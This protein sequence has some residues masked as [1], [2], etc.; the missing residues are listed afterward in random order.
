[1]SI[2]AS[3]GLLT[4]DYMKVTK[5]RVYVTPKSFLDLLRLYRYL[6]KTKKAELLER[7]DKFTTGLDKM[8][9]IT[10][11]IDQSKLDLEKLRPVLADKVT[12][13]RS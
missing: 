1:M 3:V 11:V 12:M 4:E 2:H 5:R 10:V 13:C 9:E 8:S 6:L 7:F